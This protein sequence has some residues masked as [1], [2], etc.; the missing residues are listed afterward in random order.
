MAEDL[1]RFVEHKPIL[2]RRTS[3]PALMWSWARRNRLAATLVFALASSLIVGLLVASATSIYLKRVVTERSQRLVDA[4]LNEAASLRGSGLPGQRFKAIQ[5]LREAIEVVPSLASDAKLREQLQTEL[6]GA[7]GLPD[8]G[9]TTEWPAEDIPQWWH[10]Y[11]HGLGRYAHRNPDRTQIFVRDVAT[12]QIVQQSTEQERCDHVTISPN[13]RW[14]AWAS[15]NPWR[16]VVHDLKVKSNVLN[17]NTQAFSSA[18]NGNLTFSFS[19][20]NQVGFL[21][22]EE[23]FIL[24]DLQRDAVTHRLP[25]PAHASSMALSRDAKR[26]AV[27]T[28]ATTPGDTRQLLRAWSIDSGE[29]LF[30][31]KVLGKVHDL[32]WNRDGREL[33]VATGFAVDVWSVGDGRQ[34]LH[35]REQQI[36]TKLEYTEKGDVL[37]SSGWGPVTTFWNVAHGERMFWLPG[38]FLGNGSAVGQQAGLAVHHGDHVRFYRF[39]SGAERKVVLAAQTLSDFTSPR[40]IGVHPDGRV[41]AMATTSGVRLGDVLAGDELGDLTLGPLNSVCF[42]ED[43]MFTA[44]DHGALA[45]PLESLSAVRIRLGPPTSIDL[46]AESDGGRCH[47]WMDPGGRQVIYSV[48]FPAGPRNYLYA[49]E[50]D[51]SE[52]RRIPCLPLS[53]CSSYLPR[54]LIVQPKLLPGNRWSTL[55]YDVRRFETVAEFP[56]ARG[57]CFF[58]GWKA[59]VLIRPGRR[60]R[61]FHSG[62]RQDLPC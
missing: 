34:R 32:T 24:Y 18:L 53:V 48:F 23:E 40:G 57:G 8:V 21:D 15:G 30:S 5:A 58:A 25:L 47:V 51:Q 19:Y 49:Q 43:M 59:I 45:W 33:A 6:I 2:T 35:L 11:H 55:V 22:R 27:C 56:G 38:L 28:A 42:S 41:V 9:V 37:I 13:G 7:L 46:P 14:I 20:D 4:K 3:W 52:L 61:L 50:L 29:L 16:L 62:I 39:E 12:W 36:A 1:R 17:E 31:T 44:D 54:D 60:L 10:A 26:V